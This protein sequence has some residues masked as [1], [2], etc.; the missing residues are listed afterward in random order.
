MR[1]DEAD[2]ATVPL[3]LLA[4]ACVPATLAAVVL[5]GRL[6]AAAALPGA[7]KTSFSVTSPADAA[8]TE[9]A[10]SVFLAD[11][12]ITSGSHSFFTWCITPAYITHA[13]DIARATQSSICMR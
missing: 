10:V 2:G 9:A 8:A 11:K 13:N 12:S 6:S 4:S 3:C 5:D 7:E 1:G